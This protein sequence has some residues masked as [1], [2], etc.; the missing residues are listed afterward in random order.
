[1]HQHID[2]VGPP[3][4]AIVL[5]STTDICLTTVMRVGC[6]FAAL[7][8]AVNPPLLCVQRR[9][10]IKEVKYQDSQQRAE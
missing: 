7:G 3:C 8:V 1:M 10:S 9:A 4:P 2:G 6:C 5:V